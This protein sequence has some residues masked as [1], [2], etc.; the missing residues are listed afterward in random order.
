MVDDDLHCCNN[1]SSFSISANKTNK[2]N[3]AI[4]DTGATDT[5]IRKSTSPNSAPAMH[6][7]INV[8]L[9]N[10]QTIAPIGQFRLQLGNFELPA[11]VCHDHQLQQSLISVADYVNQGCTAVFTKTGATISDVD[12]EVIVEATKKSDE[13]LWTLNLPEQ[14]SVQANNVI[15][16]QVNAELVD[17]W[18][19][20]LGSPP[21]STLIKACRNDFLRT[22]PKL[23]TSMVSRNLPTSPATA[24]GH[25]NLNRQQHKSSHKP[26]E[27]IID[28]EDQH[29]SVF[30]TGIT[31]HVD[32]TGKFPVQSHRGNNY[33]LVGVFNNYIHV[34][35]MASRKAKD[36]AQA[37]VA[38]YKWLADLGHRPTMQRMDNEFSESLHKILTDLQLQ[39]EFVPPNNHRANKAERAIQD[40][41]NHLIA[42][43]ATAAKDFPLELWDEMLPQLNITI[44]LLR[45]YG[46]N[47]NQSAY[48]AIH[49]EPFDFI[50][51]PLAPAGTA[52]MVHESS[53]TRPTWAPHAVSGFYLGPALQH[54]KCYRVYIPATKS[55]RISDSVH[56]INQTFYLPGSGVDEL[57]LEAISEFGQK[58][59]KVLDLSKSSNTTA[60]SDTSTYQTLM[61]NLHSMAS[62]VRPS[63]QQTSATS[64]TDEIEPEFNDDQHSDDTTD[65]FAA[66]SHS[67]L[68]QQPSLDTTQQLSTTAIEPRV[69]S[70]NTTAAI[71]RVCPEKDQLPITQVLT[72]PQPDHRSQSATT[73]ITALDKNK[74]TASASRISN[75]VKNLPQHLTNFDVIRFS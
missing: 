60:T 74:S 63:L 47:P 36:V 5:L 55:I 1:E 44:N 30:V 18:H 25:L 22:V 69:V 56:W 3:T 34:V 66:L 28:N 21:N 24:K 50:K 31:N 26:D 10:G 35:P 39:V 65:D 54:H 61:D 13:K 8:R 57:L 59:Q 70:D 41:K 71:P 38:M 67:A 75:R 42:M 17:F 73:S 49:G 52:I 53:Q 27:T 11:H 48:E 2:T 4:L 72:Q 51:H 23:T 43:L 64:T 19:K 45:P 7:N 15:S 32:I 29:D 68:S 33:L 6:S 58:L 14:H 12:G 37:H 46:P 40:V 16:H 9:P 62:K 20:T